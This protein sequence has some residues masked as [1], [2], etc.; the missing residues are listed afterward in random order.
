MQVTSPGGAVTCFVCP[1]HPA[2][3]P[4][5]ARLDQLRERC[6]DVVEV[7]VEEIGV[8]VERDHS[9]VPRRA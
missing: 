5:R 7:V 6:G 3:I 1:V 4:L 9:A 2:V 8:G